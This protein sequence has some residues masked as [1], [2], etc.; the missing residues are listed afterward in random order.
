MTGMRTSEHWIG[1]KPTSGTPNGTSS[2]WDPATGAQQAEVV[3]GSAADV[4]E[5]VPAAVSAAGY[6]FPTSS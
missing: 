6:H 2:V 5:A 3:L 4:E 1:G